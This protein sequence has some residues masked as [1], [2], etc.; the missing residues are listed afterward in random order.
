MQRGQM[1]NMWETRFIMI[2]PK[3]LANAT[4]M[5]LHRHIKTH[6][7]YRFRTSPQNP[8]ENRNENRKP[9]WE[10]TSATKPKQGKLCDRCIRCAYASAGM[11]TPQQLPLLVYIPPLNLE[12]SFDFFL[13]EI[14]DFLHPFKTF[15]LNHLKLNNR[16]YYLST[17]VWRVW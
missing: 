14:F 7:S 17:S 8:R 1:Q 3:L 4:V 5:R 12:S 13:Q 15:F 16:G 6:A 10:T 2:E 9:N 11:P